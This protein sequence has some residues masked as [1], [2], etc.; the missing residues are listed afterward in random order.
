MSSLL[1]ILVVAV[2]WLALATNALAVSPQLINYQGTLSDDQGQPLE[3]TYSLTFKIYAGALGG[4][5]LWT[6]TQASVAVADGL[7][8]VVL[9]G[10]SLPTSLFSGADRWLGVTVG[11]GA[12]LT[13]RMRFTS[14]PWALRATV[15]DTALVGVGG[16]DGDWTI[17]GSNQY[18]AVAGNV[19]IGTTS[20]GK[21]LQVGSNTIPNS[22]GM[23]RLG[24]RSGTNGSNRIWDIG[25][26]ETD[27][28]SS[29]IG[30]SFIIDDTQ[31]FNE[32]EF[33]VKFDTGNVGIGTITPEAKLTVDGNILATAEISG[34][35]QVSV[36]NS[37]GDIR[38]QI[39]VGSEDAGSVTAYSPTISPTCR[40]ETL[41]GYPENGYISVHRY[42]YMQAG[43][44]VNS[45]GN[46]VVFADVK[47]FR[48]PSRRD[49][50]KDI[51]YASLEGPEAAA[52]VRGTAVLTG[53]AATVV[54]PEHFQE[55]A[56]LAGMTVQVTPRSAESRGL[57]VVSRALDGFVVRELSA[58]TGTYEFDWE[59]KA[60]R[61][62]HQ[63][64]RVERPWDDAL[65]SGLD[66]EAAWQARLTAIQ[67]R[68]RTQR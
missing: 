38:A 66:R 59:V 42:S 58:G 7:F 2:V 67:E 40:M 61:R 57:A 21:R 64:Y 63:D 11:A 34:R 54:L 13:P 43:M 60:V 44:Y 19:G 47:N 50:T 18:S 17:A 9:G 32:V 52:Y 53:G 6:Q 55:V 14:V 65:P 62:A 48:E 3:G 39:S 46:G 26:P 1:K 27:G 41:Y 51:W 36:T 25:V 4:S 45:D 16:S 30:Y 31:N 33:M 23:I 5:P 35:D 15:A 22:E 29:G 24:S 10:T 49:Q 20:P 37:T 8:N 12:E 68:E 56:A 28:V